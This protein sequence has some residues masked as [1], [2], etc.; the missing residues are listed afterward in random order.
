MDDLG[1]G[2][3]ETVGVYGIARIRR[4]HHI[5]G[6][7]DRGGEV[8]EPFLG[9][10]GDDDLGFRVQR[11]AETALVIGGHGAPQAGDAARRRITVGSR[12]AHRFHEFVDDVLRSRL[13]GVAHAE[14]DHVA[15]GGPGAALHVVDRREHVRRQAFDAF[16]MGVHPARPPE[17]RARHPRGRA[18]NRRRER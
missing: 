11:D 3:D 7:G 5:A 17:R 13:V 10:E 15:T 18:F 12:L 14:I 8:G 1:P 6:D 4:Q 2:D 9:A 16:E